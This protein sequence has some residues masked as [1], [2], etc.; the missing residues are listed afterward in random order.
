M[1]LPT[2]LGSSRLASL[3]LAAALPLAVV[4]PTELLLEVLGVLDSSLT[5]GRTGPSA[6]S[7]AGTTGES[8]GASMR[9]VAAIT[10]QT[11]LA[12]ATA[13][14]RGSG[15]RML[16]RGSLHQQE[17]QQLLQHVP[18]VQRGGLSLEA[19]PETGAY[20]T[21]VMQFIMAFGISFLL[22]LLL[23]LRRGPPVASPPVAT[24]P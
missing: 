16:L 21:L 2:L 22:P 23:L 20:L 8:A 24:A 6:H 12:M 10:T 14:S 5:T 15:T 11:G 18:A 19:L 3:L 1:L 13:V 9:R 7:V 4:H 17:G